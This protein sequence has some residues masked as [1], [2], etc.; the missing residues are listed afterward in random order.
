MADSHVIGELR[1]IRSGLLGFDRQLQ[2]GDDSKEAQQALELCQRWMSQPP[3][4]NKLWDDVTWNLGEAVFQGMRVHELEWMLTDGLLLPKRV[5][6]VP[7]RRWHFNADNELR[8]LTKEAPYEGIAVPE[9]RFL[10]TSTC[11]TVTTLMAWH[12]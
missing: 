12:C 2:A 3:S 1:S 6:D 7:N 4:K 5:I 9:G 11:M 8:L 10:L